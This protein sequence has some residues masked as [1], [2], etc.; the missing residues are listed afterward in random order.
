M[1]ILTKEVKIGLTAIAAAVLVFI[2]I[3]F[4]KGINLFQASNT[5]YVKFK[6]INGLAV[7]NPVYANGYPVGIVRDIQYDYGSTENVIVTIELDDE[8]RVPRGTTAELES[9][10][11]GGVKMNLRLGAN[12]TQFIAQGDTLVGSPRLG[13]MSQVEAALPQVMEML[14]K[15]DSILTNINRITA[16]PALAKTLQNAEQLTAELNEASARLNS[17]MQRDI[18]GTL[19]RLDR[20]LANAEKLTGNLAAVDVE[21]T[22]AEVNNTLESL[23][24]FSAQLND[25]SSLLNQK[26]TSK[27][28]TLGLFL[29]DRGVYDNL[30]NTMMSADSLLTDFKAHPKRYIHFS[31]FGKKDK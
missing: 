16:D 21:Q 12:P 25:M 4:L 1:K 30:N 27:D 19:K 3:N 22:M 14:P 8:M 2:G 9:E 17:M 5:Y 7:S 6:D 23:Q 11:M 18:P 15:I 24:T 31:V 13:A 29:N 28:N 20:T 10:L 26:M